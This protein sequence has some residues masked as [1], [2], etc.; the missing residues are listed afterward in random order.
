MSKSKLYTGTG[1]QGT[2]SLVGGERVSK[3]CRRLE[4][5]GTVDEFSSFLGVVLS[6]P[7]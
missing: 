4:A 3:C 6:T 5:Y 7:T 1:D 2:T